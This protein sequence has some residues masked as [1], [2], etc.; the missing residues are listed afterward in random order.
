M[1]SEHLLGTFINEKGIGGTT[2]AHIHEQLIGIVNG[3]NKVF[4][5]S[6]NYI[7]NSEI[8]WFDGVRLQ[9]DGDYTRSAGNTITFIEAPK[10]RALPKEN[11]I[12]S[13][14]YIPG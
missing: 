10:A 3:I 7:L 13:I 14:Q 2:D 8:V 12:V 5:T 6:V 4:T 1:S 9:K 11:S